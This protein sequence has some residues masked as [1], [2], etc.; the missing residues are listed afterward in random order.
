MAIMAILFDIDDT[1]V[2]E[3]ASAEASFLATCE[4]ALEQYGLNPNALY[5]AVRHHARLLWRASPT[6]TYC[7]AIGVSSWEG[8]WARF[9]GDE[10][11]LKALREWAPT[12]R[13]E[14]W[15]RALADFGVYDLP[16]A[17][18][19]AAMFQ[20]ERRS[21][22]IV[23]PDVEPALKDLRG[24][25]RLAIVTNGVPDLQREK[26]QGANL[27]QYFDAVIISGEV[28]IGK[29]EPHIFEIALDKLAVYPE[30]AVMVGD[31]LNRDIIGAQQ[32]G[33]RGIWINRSGVDCDEDVT[34]D[35]QISSLSELGDV[36]Q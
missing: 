23:F 20:N 36:L 30:M 9:L 13:R 19:L 27:A 14:S 3:E 24:T 32:A 4:R 10:P 2:V 8:L 22:H 17:E 35:A 15:A 11:N 16:F 7:R 31:S 21:R 25:Y 34:P 33:L 18:Q 26:L 6:I 1:L 12:Y 29:P 5:Q 28:G